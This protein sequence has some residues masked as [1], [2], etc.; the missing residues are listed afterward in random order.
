[1]NADRTPNTLDQLLALA[2]ED[3]GAALR[4]LEQHNAV[5]ANALRRDYNLHRLSPEFVDEALHWMAP[6]PSTAELTK[7][8]RIDRY[9]IEGVLGEGGMGKVYL[10]RR[11]DVDY[12]QHVALK[13]PSNIRSDQFE[14]FAQEQRILAALNHPAI[15][16]FIDAGTANLADTTRPFI[17]MEFID[18]VPLLDYVQNQ[19]IAL[20]TRIG[21]CREVVSA[22]QFAHQNLIVHRDLKSSNL[23]VTR[24]GDIKVL[25]FGAA[26]LLGPSEAQEE[27]TRTGELLLSPRTAAPEQ[28]RGAP[29]TAATDLYQLG[30]LLY[31]VVCG[32]APIEFDTT[33][34]VSMTERIANQEPAP[35][36]R[37]P[38]YHERVD[39]DLD[40]IILKCLQKQPTDRYRSA[41]ALFDDLSAWLEDRPIRA[42]P[43]TAWQRGVKWVRRN[44]VPATLSALVLVLA[45]AYTATMMVQNQTIRKALARAQQESQKAQQTTQFLSEIFSEIR[46]TNAERA[47]LSARELLTQS[48]TRLSYQFLDQPQ[49]KRVL[50]NTIAEIQQEL[51]LFESSQELLLQLDNPN[52]VSAASEPAPLDQGELAATQHLLGVSYLMLEDFAEAQEA[53]DK[54]LNK[55][56]EAPDQLRLARVLNDYGLLRRREENLI[57]AQALYRQA[58]AALPQSLI[59]QDAVVSALAGEF[60]NNLGMV[61]WAEGKLQDA[62]VEHQRA[63]ELRETALGADHWMLA[64]SLNNAATAH[65]DL[66]HYEQAKRGHER[67]LAIQQ[68]TLGP[69][70]RTVAATL[71]DLGYTHLYMGEFDAAEKAMTQAGSIFAE[72]DGTQSQAYGRA[73]FAKGFLAKQQKNYEAAETT[74]SDLVTLRRALYGNHHPAVGRALLRV[75]DAKVY[76][77]M[78]QAALALANEGLSMVPAGQ[79]SAS[80]GLF[81]AGRAQLAIGAR[82]QG[83]ASLHS[84]VQLRMRLL[85]AEHRGVKEIQTLLATLGVR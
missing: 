24:Q 27:L 34:L 52:V 71:I 55:L 83:I 30:L 17:A 79:L 43:V 7:G 32:S 2:P 80:T 58:L 28:V 76:L 68:A 60:H 25:D 69:Q 12:E 6:Q 67:A 18:G 5:R 20:R 77:G 9:Q 57:A 21:L 72:L 59:G 49:T 11:A 63:I 73:L 4:R 45:T 51:S 36:T 10:A 31:E 61:F 26:K 54:A 75:A 22:V 64:M 16:R 48:A 13:L 53:F 65:R 40:A 23:L 82:E 3:R 56:A 37:R 85:P 47:E 42:R 81:I 39:A 84:A 33:D 1:M 66:G 38:E 19:R 50:V 62:L 35:P 74:F 70:H 78:A 14:R 15:S 46:P 8:Q 29:I 44:P 41:D